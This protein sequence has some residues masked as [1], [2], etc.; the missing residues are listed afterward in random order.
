MDAAAADT[1][2]K[3]SGENGSKFSIFITG[4][5]STMNNVS[6]AT[7]IATRMEL[8]KALSLVPITSSQVWL[9]RSD[10]LPNGYADSA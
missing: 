4:T 2:A 5:A 9:T 3:P 1:P 10:S 7:L 6:A 8:T